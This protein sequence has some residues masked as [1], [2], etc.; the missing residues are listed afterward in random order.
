MDMVTYPNRCGGLDNVLTV[1]TDLVKKLDTDKL[2]KLA[3][4]T[5]EIT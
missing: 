2:L 4:I 5:D 3:L 1:L